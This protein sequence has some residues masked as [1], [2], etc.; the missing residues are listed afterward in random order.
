MISAAIIV[1]SIKAPDRTGEDQSTMATSALQNPETSTA[2]GQSMGHL[3]LHYGKPEDGPVA[4]RLLKL[5]GL[6]ETQMLPL[7]QGNFYR[8]V[9]NS[10][11]LSRG[12]GIVYLSAM[13]EPQAK[14]VEAIHGAL[15][16]GTDHE[17][18]AVSGYREMM[19]QD[20]EASFHLGFLVDSLEA[21]ED[22]VLK[23]S[24]VAEN[25]P[26]L[27]GR[28]TLGMNR[29]RPGNA[30]VDARLDASPVF[31]DCTRYAYGSNGVQVF[32]K[33]DVVKA[34]Q[35]GEDMYFELD[36]VF[37]GHDSHILSVVEL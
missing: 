37:P 9:V 36:Y 27:K 25:D 31:G 11:H 2:A 18:E 33:T 5:L 21:L 7:P 32:V 1:R 23:L 19:A 15:G 20:F 4:A 34:G 17:H 6:E 30:E 3:A 24:E 8:F 28:V 26:E 35:L 16:L 29:P 13:P 14:L 10:S 22:T 12:D